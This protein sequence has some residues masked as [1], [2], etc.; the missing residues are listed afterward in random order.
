MTAWPAN[1]LIFGKALYRTEE[2]EYAE[3]VG[4]IIVA[5]LTRMTR[6]EAFARKCRDSYLA[7]LERA[8]GHPC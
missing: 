6:N 8:M 5:E 2:D 1:D 7:A 3:N 4:L